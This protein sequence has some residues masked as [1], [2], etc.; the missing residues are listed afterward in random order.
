VR[1]VGLGAA[2]A[3]V[4]NWPG[5]FTPNF[6]RRGAFPNL[7]SSRPSICY[8]SYAFGLKSVVSSFL[9]IS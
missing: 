5:G 7:L 2:G 3:L 8:S 1:A 6:E 9:Q 4:P